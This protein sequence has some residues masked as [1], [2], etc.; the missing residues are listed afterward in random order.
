MKKT[1]KVMAAIMLV[2]AMVFSIAS[3]GAMDI[4]KVQGDWHV[5]TVNG[6]TVADY[7]AS[8][9]SV[10]AGAM[11]VI[12]VKDKNFSQ[13]CLVDMSGTLDTATG[14]IEMAKDG[15]IVNLAGIDF[16]YVLD[17]KAGT[18]TTKFKQGDT[19]YTYVYVKGSYDLAGKLAEQV[20][21]LNGGSEG[22]AE[23][24]EEYSE[25]DYGEY[26]EEDYGE[27]AEE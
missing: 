15:F 8:I 26:S 21:A 6:Q 16:G 1:I 4:S 25:E 23:G 22:S 14:T 18:L 7:A 2:A 5:S 10:E 20:A 24:G 12:S 9:G 13:S 11:K 3:C 27:Y 17:E 19:E